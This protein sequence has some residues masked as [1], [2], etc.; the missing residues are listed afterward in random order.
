MS[1]LEKDEMLED[2]GGSRDLEDFVK[3]VLD[4]NE[5]GWI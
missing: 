2:K 1:K 4:K 3:Y 5:N